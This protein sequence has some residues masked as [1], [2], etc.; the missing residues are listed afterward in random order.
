MQCSVSQWHVCYMCCVGPAGLS[1]SMQ[2]EGSRQVGRHAR[3]LEQNA[4]APSLHLLCLPAGLLAQVLRHVQT[5]RGR[6]GRIVCEAYA[7][8]A[9]TSFYRQLLVLRQP[10]GGW[11]YKALQGVH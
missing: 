9:S 10:P 6:A 3:K 7:R 5:R 8:G 2:E 4:P 1:C 11:T